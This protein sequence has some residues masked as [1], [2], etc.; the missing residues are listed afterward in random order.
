MTAKIFL[1]NGFEVVV[2][3]KEP[4]LGGVWT[5]SRT[6]PGL[7]ANNAKENY[8]FSDYSYPESTNGYPYAHEIRNYLESYADHFDI[9]PCIRFNCEVT[10]LATSEA[11]AK[12]GFE[13]TIGAGGENAPET[14]HFPFVVICNGPFST[15]NLPDF[16]GMGSFAGQIRHSSQCI[17]AEVAEAERVITVGGGKS[18]LDCAASAALK[19]KP[20]TLV[21]RKAHWMFPRYLPGGARSDLRISTRFSELF[22]EHPNRPRFEKFLHGP[23]KP[24]VKLWW[25]FLSKVVPLA[26][27]MPQLLIPEHRLPIGF[28]SAGV[29]DDYF[30]LLNAG[31]ITAKRA[32]IAK[33][34]ETGVELDSGERLDADLIVF[35]TGWQRDLSFLEESLR[36]QIFRSDRFRLFRRILPP[37]QQRLAFVG[38]FPTLACQL[39]SEVAAHWTAQCFNGALELPTV[40]EMDREIERLEDWAKERLPDSSD[41]IFTGPYQSHYIN[42]LMCDMNMQIDRT[43]NFLTEYLGSYLSKRYATLGQELQEARENKSMSR[44]RFYFSSLHALAA[45][46]LV[47][48]L[49]LILG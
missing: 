12:S 8:C 28:E 41:G 46:L 14:L 17:D 13:L 42:D 15:T 24:I 4:A 19:D 21:F 48:A 23:G 22:V 37:V 44:S 25:A 10:H 40:A 49:W 39:S 20:S 47:A 26:A 30:D 34:T 1:S 9:R 32:S 6:Y 33:F 11:N 7:R 5:A 2:F 31:R 18:A 27:E 38:Y 16:E 43:S 29:I 36:N 35:A 3:E 45:I